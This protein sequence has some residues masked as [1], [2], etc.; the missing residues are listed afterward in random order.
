MFCKRV[1]R[2]K[3]ISAP[4]ISLVRWNEPY[5][6]LATCDA[7]GIIFVWIR[8][9]GRWSIELINDRNR[10]VSRW[11]VFY[12]R[13]PLCSVRLSSRAISLIEFDRSFIS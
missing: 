2:V 8:Y 12:G 6:K 7:S 9:E 11:R 5:Q 10:P 13:G 4:Q 1:A 3:A